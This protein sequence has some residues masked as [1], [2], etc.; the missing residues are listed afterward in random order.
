MTTAAHRP[1][2]PLTPDAC[3]AL[4]REHDI[5][6]DQPVVVPLGGGVSNTVFAV[7]GGGRRVV[8]K[9]SLER[10]RVTE[11]W[12]APLGRVL[13][14]AAALDLAHSVTPQHVPTVLFVDPTR[15]VL[16]LAGAP[17]E[18]RD[19]KSCLLTGQVDSWVAQQL[20]G[21]LAAWHNATREGALLQPRFFDSEPFELLRVDPYY[22][23]VA[24]KRP[25][26]S[27][28][29]HDLIDQM[30]SRRQCLVHG[31]FSPKNVL[32]DDLRKACWVI[33]FE[34]AHYGDPAFDVS[35]LLAHL[36]LKSLHKPEHRQAYDKC[37]SMFVSAY[38]DQT[39]TALAPELPYVMR[40]VGALLAARALGKSP[41]EYLSGDQAQSMDASTRG[42]AC[43][44]RVRGS[45]GP[46]SGQVNAG[47]H[48]AADGERRP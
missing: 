2:E 17:A 10:L 22:R 41:A 23:T 1:S 28:P 40:H 43:V 3:L 27:G 14:E 5:H 34:V 48:V 19:W 9:Q 12:R 15:Y 18:W 29:L 16:A 46:L 11:E 7:G 42:A 25:D 39:S 24:R 4:I 37:A 26:L 20:G 45:P 32:V 21:A 13:T 8:V 36:L 35:F 31:D 30:N 38:A 6:V 44:D 47:N 33:D